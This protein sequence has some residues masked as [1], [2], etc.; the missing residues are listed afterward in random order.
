[1]DT[2]S[3]RPSLERVDAAPA[4]TLDLT[5]EAVPWPATEMVR[6]L[7]QSGHP[8]PGEE[9]DAVIDLVVER[10]PVPEAGMYV[11]WALR[12]E[13]IEP[14]IDQLV[15]LADLIRDLRRAGKRV[16]V[17]C[18]G[19]INRSSLLAGA[20]LIRD[21]VDPDEVITL[22][23]ERRPGALNNTTFERVL[24]EKLPGQRPRAAR[25]RGAE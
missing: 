22:L 8:E 1:M 7:W 6:G 25:P 4:D 5:G 17:H 19:G 24:R 15:A 2:A 13:P 18:A 23:R 11:R 12:D 14:D 10:E 20:S 16:L 21:G 9:W 3:D